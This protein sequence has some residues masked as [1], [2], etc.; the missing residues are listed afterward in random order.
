M[1]ADSDPLGAVAKSHCWKS[2]TTLE[3][4]GMSLNLTVMARVS[5]RVDVH[6][7]QSWI[8]IHSVDLIVLYQ[9]IKSTQSTQISVILQK[10]ST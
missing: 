4:R 1:H 6:R 5:G 8:I 7:S 10:P 9:K 3:Q 2:F